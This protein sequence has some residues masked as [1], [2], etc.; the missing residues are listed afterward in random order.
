MCR[1]FDDGLKYESRES[2]TTSEFPKYP[3]QGLP[4]TVCVGKK[5]KH[6]VP[7]PIGTP[8]D[9]LVEFAPIRAAAINYFLNL[10]AARHGH[11]RRWVVPFSGFQ[12]TT[13]A[14]RKGTCAKERR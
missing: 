12:R 5:A 10:L 4:A 7:E 9:T 1:S 2:S 8:R 13:G 6:Q 14:I 3:S 11:S